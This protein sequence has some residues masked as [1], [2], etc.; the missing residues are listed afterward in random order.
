M[1]DEALT[2][3]MQTPW[4][5]LEGRMQDGL[6][7]RHL[8]ADL[9]WEQLSES[10][11]DQGDA[12]AA[13]WQ[14]RGGVQVRAYALEGR[15]GIEMLAESSGGALGGIEKSLSPAPLAG[16][17][18]RIDVTLACTSEP[19]VTALRGVRLSVE[20][21][22]LAGR[23][24]TVALPLQGG[25]SPGW[26]TESFTLHFDP[27]LGSAT[28]RIDVIQP[29]GRIALQRTRVVALPRSLPDMGGLES[30]S[31]P[32]NLVVDGDF[33][34]GQ[35]R[36]FA[37]ATRRRPDGSAV[38]YP[39][40][41]EYVEGSV[42]GRRALWLAQDGESA[43]VGFGPLDLTRTYRTSDRRLMWHLSF[44]ARSSAAGAIQ[45]TLKDR[46][47]TIGQH[48]FQTKTTW[49]RYTCTFIAEPPT[50]TK[51]AELAGTELLMDFTAQGGSQ[52]IEHWLDV[53]ALTPIPLGSGLEEYP[54]SAAMEVGLAPPETPSYDLR[55][56]IDRGDAARF[57]MTLVGPVNARNAPSGGRVALDVL[58]AWD[59]SVW[60][61]TS[62]INFNTEGFQEESA[63]VTLGQGYYRVLATAWSGA[64]GESD[65]LSHA[66]LP[67]ALITTH[68]TIP[69]NGRYGLTAAEGIASLRTTHLGAGWIRADLAARQVKSGQGRD[70]TRWR[71]VMRRARSAGSNVIVGFTLP[72][73]GELD[74]FLR[75]WLDDEAATPWALVPSP[76]VVSG[77]PVQEY[78]QQ[79][80]RIRDTLGELNRETV[81][82][83]DLSVTGVSA[84]RT[85]E[86]NAARQW[87]IVGITCAPTRLPEQTES[88]LQTIAQSVPEGGEI[89]DLRV[90]VHLSDP[91]R[92]EHLTLI[93]SSPPSMQ[94]VS[95]LDS[96]APPV[97]AASRMIRSVLIRGLVGAARV[98]SAAHSLE[99]V[100]SIHQPSHLRMHELDHAPRPA[101][102]AFDWMA[103]LLNHADPVRWVDHPGQCRLLGFAC[104][105]GRRIIAVWRPYGLQ[106]SVMQFPGLPGATQRYD[107]FGQR[108]T[109]ARKSGTALLPVNE[110]VQYLVIPAG[111]AG[112]FDNVLSQA[113]ILT[114]DPPGS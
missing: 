46:Y 81:L 55:G 20:A 50:L 66:Q 70:F 95:M 33:E 76:P 61:R 39:L 73:D 59:R 92:L 22:D 58:D 85:S 36:F 97:I 93:S 16:R 84:S 60:S 108:I 31:G 10:R 35:P 110:C 40:L 41:W 49:E 43:R 56:L 27:A 65:L 57:T 102:A 34:T 112:S 21:R 86:M 4:S 107:L 18:V 90:P 29:G 44:Y 75:A 62:P 13:G 32:V 105:D 52:P 69:R 98:C 51:R 103:Y 89:W 25:I 113:R 47:A 8:P 28:L 87:P 82:V 104:D 26:E 114:D 72:S 15:T 79:M 11:F 14:K 54:R 68:D 30:A 77:N 9:E 101:V 45:A 38:A 67:L 78:F 83:R 17:N 48:R 111:H 23:S 109:L 12:P 3:R 5:F 106:P 37:G 94:P 64:P 99:P 1:R 74:A 19:Q 7:K 6:R 100:L 71:E 91:S 2:T 63:S 88:L 53:V 96:P 42:L 80:A 24:H